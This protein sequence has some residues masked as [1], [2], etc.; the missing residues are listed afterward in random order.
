ML[1]PSTAN[2]ALASLKESLLPHH[3]PLKELKARII[4]AQNFENALRISEVEK[5]LERLLTTIDLALLD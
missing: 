3:I 2:P 5:A 4:A 1:A